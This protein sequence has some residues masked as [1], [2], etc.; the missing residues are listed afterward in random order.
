MDLVG[1]GKWGQSGKVSG[2]FKNFPSFKRAWHVHIKT[3]HKKC[4]CVYTKGIPLKIT[5]FLNF[6]LS[7]LYRIADFYPQEIR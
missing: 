1:K 7:V 4:S 3:Y 5:Q 2:I 6:T